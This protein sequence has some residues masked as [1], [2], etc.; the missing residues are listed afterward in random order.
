MDLV[1]IWGL[2]GGTPPPG[3]RTY[4]PRR[5]CTTFDFPKK[6]NTCGVFKTHM[7]SVLK[8]LTEGTKV[9]SIWPS[10]PLLPL[11]AES[12]NAAKGALVRELIPTKPERAHLDLI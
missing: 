12:G 11:Q 7:W 4:Q 10:R 2:A 8:A 6:K 5:S 1:P 9:T 3:N